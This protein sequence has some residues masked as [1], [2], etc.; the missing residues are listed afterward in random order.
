MQR[1][2]AF[3]LVGFNNLLAPV[4]LQS[5][6]IRLRGCFLQLAKLRSSSSLSGNFSPTCPIMNQAHFSSNSIKPVNMEQATIPA[7]GWQ[8]ATAHL[9]P[10]VARSWG[11]SAETNFSEFVVREERATSSVAKKSFHL[12]S[13]VSVLDRVLRSVSNSVRRNDSTTERRCLRS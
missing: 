6:I 8:A 4:P 2:N 10:S 12:S 9:P 11:G 7:A 13:A 1:S 5:K 3:P